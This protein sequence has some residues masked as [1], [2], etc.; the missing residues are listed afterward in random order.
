MSPLDSRGLDGSVRTARAGIAYFTLVIR[1]RAR[2]DFAAVRRAL[3]LPRLRRGELAGPAQ[4]L[5]ASRSSTSASVGTPPMAPAFVQ[6]TAAAAFA[7]QSWRSSGHPET[8][9]KT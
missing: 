1:G 5:R 2:P 9:P 6:L 7:N 4:D 3:L 8:M